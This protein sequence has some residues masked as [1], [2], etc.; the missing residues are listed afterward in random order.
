MIAEKAGKGLVLSYHDLEGTPE[1]LDGLY[2]SM[3]EQGADI[4]KIAVTPRSIADLGRLFEFA[5]RGARRGA[6]PSCPRHGPDGHREPH[7][8]RALRGAFHCSR[9]RPPE[10]RP[11]PDRSPPP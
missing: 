5:A 9:L 2:A 1:D 3:A 4:V 8:R 11:L 6:R 10:P 7:P